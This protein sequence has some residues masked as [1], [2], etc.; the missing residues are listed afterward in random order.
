MFKRAED[1]GRRALTIHVEGQAISAREGDT[2]SAALLASGLDVRRDTAVSGAKR[3]P[4]C[5][6]GVCFD[7][8]V[9]IDGVGNRQGCLVP[10]AEGMQIEIQKGKREIGK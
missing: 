5:M 7:C 3:L 1:D 10:V 4:Y 6:M 2:V 8:L 9:T